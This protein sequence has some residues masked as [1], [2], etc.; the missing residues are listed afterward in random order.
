M[1]PQVETL[2]H[3]RLLSAGSLDRFFGNAGVV[4]TSIV[5][6]DDG[7]WMDSVTLSDGRL[8]TAGLFESKGSGPVETPGAICVRE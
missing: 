8:L 3:R 5:D 4:S 2:E 1:K 6:Q 7:I